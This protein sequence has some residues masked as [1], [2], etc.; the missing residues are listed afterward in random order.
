[1]RYNLRIHKS[2]NSGFAMRIW[3]DENDSSPKPVVTASTKAMHHQKQTVSKNSKRKNKKHLPRQSQDSVIHKSGH[4]DETVVLDS[5]NVN[6]IEPKPRK[7]KSPSA[8]RRDIKRRR[9]WRIRRR[10]A[11]L[12]P[13]LRDLVIP[14]TVD[15]SSVTPDKPVPNKCIDNDMSTDDCNDTDSIVN[16][17]DTDTSGVSDNEH[18]SDEDSN[19]LENSDHSDNDTS[20]SDLEPC[21]ICQKESA[22]D[23]GYCHFVDLCSQDILTYI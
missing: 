1:M 2:S 14:S 6:D 23:C 16:C 19:A 9:E 7:K 11:R 21:A 4:S 18:Q 20:V 8:I 10:Q 13:R 15:R 22:I 17:R 5:K 12:P 3:I